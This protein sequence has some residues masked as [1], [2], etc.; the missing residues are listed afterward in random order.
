MLK[1]TRKQIITFGI[2]GI[3]GAG[4]LFSGIALNSVYAQEETQAVEVSEEVNGM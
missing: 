2:T 1:K 3:V 4:S